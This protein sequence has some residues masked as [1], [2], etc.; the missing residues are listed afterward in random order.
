M[1]IHTST[2]Q[3]SS[4]REAVLKDAM[5]QV[6]MAGGFTALRLTVARLEAEIGRENR[7]LLAL[8]GWI[9]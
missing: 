4:I 9:A 2:S 1:N 8:Q 3:R 6:F 7:A 5:E